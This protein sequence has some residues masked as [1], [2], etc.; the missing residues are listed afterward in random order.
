MCSEIGRLIHPAIAVGNEVKYENSL[1]KL[2]VPF[3]YRR[4][5]CDS[6][7]NKCAHRLMHQHHDLFYQYGIRTRVPKAGMKG[8]DKLYIPQYRRDVITYPCR[9]YL[10]LIRKPS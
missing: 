5:V 4:A 7:S 10:L 1:K 2:F 8:S 9:W 3:Q 6:C